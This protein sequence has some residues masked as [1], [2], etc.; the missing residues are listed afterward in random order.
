[1]S[2]FFPADNS[3]IRKPR[4]VDLYL[5]HRWLKWKE[6]RLTLYSFQWCSMQT[7]THLGNLFIIQLPKPDQH[8]VFIMMTNMFKDIEWS[9][10][11][12]SCG[13]GECGQMLYIFQQFSA[14]SSFHFCLKTTC[15]VCLCVNGL[16]TVELLCSESCDRASLQA[17][18]IVTCSCGLSITGLC[19]LLQQIG[20]P[21]QFTVTVQWVWVEAPINTHN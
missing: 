16:T 21:Q 13:C 1:M 9:Q 4:R 15:G 11:A 5:F 14:S 2:C 6:S 17:A 20:Q 10:W 19:V 18:W 12:E 7:M 8:L 3:D